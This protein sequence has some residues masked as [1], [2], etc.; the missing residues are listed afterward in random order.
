[1][2]K[3][4]LLACCLLFGFLAVFFFT[5]K[6]SRTGTISYNLNGKTY[7]LLTAVNA[8]QWEQGLMYYRSLK[9]ADGMMFI[10]PDSQYR[11]FWNKNTYMNLD[12]YWI[13]GKTV[14]GK[15]FLPSIEKSRTTVIINAPGKVDKVIELIAGK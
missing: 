8:V 6:I 12:V 5:K 11:S 9:N 2:K 3:I 14:V 15:N 13:N 1:M 4:I 10:F 7:H